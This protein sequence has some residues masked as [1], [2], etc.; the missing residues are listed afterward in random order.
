MAIA[1][2]SG[3]FGNAI[4]VSTSSTTEKIT[5]TTRLEDIP[6]GLACL[7][8]AAP[9]VKAFVEHQLGLVENKI[10]FVAPDA[11]GYQC[12][13]DGTTYLSHAA[14]METFMEARKI[15][16]SRGD[17]ASVAEVDRGILFEQGVSVDS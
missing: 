12:P 8:C 17:S 14:V 15:L 2:D 10:L 1:I 5:L 3:V 7:V 6:D 4:G 13:A 9:T 11:A 16:F